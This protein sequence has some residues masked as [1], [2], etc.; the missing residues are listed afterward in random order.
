ME[1]RP[2]PPQG[3]TGGPTALGR[4][5]IIGRVARVLGR[6]WSAASSSARSP[7]RRS[8]SSRITSSTGDTLDFVLAAVALIPLA[9]LIGEATEHAAHHTGPGIGGFLNA[10]FGNAPELIIAL[11]AVNE[12]L[13]EVVRGS[14][15]GSVVGNLLLVLGFSLLVGGRGRLDRPSSL[16]LARPRRARRRCSSSSRRS[17]A[18]GRRPRRRALA[19]PVDRPGG[20]A[21]RR[22]RRGDLVVAA[23]ARARCTSP[24]RREEA[25]SWSLPPALAR[26][27]R[28][29]GRD[30]AHRRDAR[31][32]A[33]DLRR[34]GRPD[35][36]SSS[37]P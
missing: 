2:E 14:L 16:H 21:A 24:T 6:P 33:R 30:R 36:T 28:R 1:R 37:R 19:A 4:S 26:P 15:T 12:G 35:A 9:W 11:I 27:R 7:S 23:A 34:G 13:P 20:R 17:R 22:L 29:D 32:L 8:R 5:A 25:D 31:P 10:T 18:S 3:L